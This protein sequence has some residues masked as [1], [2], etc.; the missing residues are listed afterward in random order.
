MSRV[1]RAAAAPVVKGRPRADREGPDRAA[2]GTDPG[3]VTD[4]RGGG[5]AG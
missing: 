4:A 5:G 1:A 2:P 3:R